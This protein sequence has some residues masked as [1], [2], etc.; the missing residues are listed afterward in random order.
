M[1]FCYNQPI[2]FIYLHVPFC[3]S[4]CIYCDFYV[5]LHKH[6]GQERFVEAVCREIDARFS[7]MSPAQR[8]QPIQTLYVGGGTPSLLNAR[9]YQRIIERLSAYASWAPDAEV[10]LEANPGASRSEMADD[11]ARYLAVGFNRVSVGVQSFQDAELKKLSRIHTAADAERFIRHL[12]Q[13]GW[14]NVSLDLMYAIPLQTQASWQDTLQRTLDLG[15]SHVSM[16]GLKIEEGTPLARLNLL[17]GGG[18]GV[19]DD[20]QNVALYQA[21][22][23]ALQAGGLQRYEFSN[24]A[25][26]GYRSRHNL[27]YWDNGEYLALGPSAH[28]YW[29]GHRYEN[30]RDL[31]A[32]IAHPTAA[33]MTPCPVQEQL[34]NALIFGLRKTEGISIEA[35]ERRYQI[36]FHQRYGHVLQRYSPLY[37]REE[38]GWLRLTEQAIPVSNMILAEFLED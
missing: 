8:D 29:Q 32:Y 33:R 3:L 23:E 13:A 5:T 38:A 34:E 22:C 18:Y 9:Q 15:V 19:P 11:S 1:G 12:R 25:R 21:G 14:T 6:G 26:E 28:G 27:N 37:L 36:D 16:Y 24:F 4:R 35:L 10:T 20:E 7:A 17:P 31:Q 2:M 30:V